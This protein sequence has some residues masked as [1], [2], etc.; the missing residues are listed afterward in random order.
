MNLAARA[1]REAQ[2]EEGS[3][4]IEFA[5]VAVMFCVLLV[6]MV[7]VSRMLLVYTTVANAVRAGERYA[8]VHGGD[9]TGSGVTGP[10]TPTS[11]SQIQTVVK[12]Y[13]SAGL[14][15]TSNLNVTVSYP[16]S[17]NAAGYP[18]KVSA[19]YTYDPMIPY[20]N[21]LLNVT[22]GST[23]EGVITF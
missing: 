7:E 4:L 11:Y 16:S 19:T 15:K 22:V 1:R 23:S 13:A 8:I 9:R 6:S 5:L 20:F 10:S 14:L 3:A 17:T 12:E 21:S 2:A 18:V